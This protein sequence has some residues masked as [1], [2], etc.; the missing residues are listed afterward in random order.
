MKAILQGR[1]KYHMPKQVYLEIKER[2]KK[3]LDQGRSKFELSTIN[4]NVEGQLIS[5]RENRTVQRK[6]KHVQKRQGILNLQD[7]LIYSKFYSDYV[8][9]QKQKA[10][11]N[12]NQNNFQK[13]TKEIHSDEE[14]DEFNEQEQ[15][16][17]SYNI[18][19]LMRNRTQDT[20]VLTSIAQKETEEMHYLTQMLRKNKKNGNNHNVQETIQNRNQLKQKINQIVDDTKEYFK[21]PPPLIIPPKLKDLTTEQVDQDF[22]RLIGNQQNIFKQPTKQIIQKNPFMKSSK[23][24]EVY[25]FVLGRTFRLLEFNIEYREKV[26]YG[27]SLCC[28]KMKQYEEGDAYINSLLNEFDNKNLKY[29]YLKAII[30]KQLRKFEIAEKYYAELF[31]RVSPFDHLILR[32]FMFAFLLKYKSKIKKYQNQQLIFPPRIHQQFV[33]VCHQILEKTIYVP[34]LSKFWSQQKKYWIQDKFEEIVDTIHKLPF[35]KRLAKSVVRKFL[36]ELKFKSCNKNQIMHSQLGTSLI[37]ISGLVLIYDHTQQF[38]KPQIVAQYSKGKNTIYFQFYYD[39]FIN[40]GDIICGN[41]YENYISLQANVW[42]IAQSDKVEYLEIEYKRFKELWK[43]QETVDGET[44]LQTLKHLKLFQGVSEL[45]LY[46]LAYELIEIKE[47]KKGD[48]IYNDCSYIESKQSDYI[49]MVKT[50]GGKT[51]L[52]YIANFFKVQ[53]GLVQKQPQNCRFHKLIIKHRQAIRQM[54]FNQKKTGGFYILLSGN[55]E[56]E[57]DKGL[58]GIHLQTKDYFGENLMIDVKGVANFGRIQASSQDVKCLMIPKYLFAKINQIDVQNSENYPEFNNQNEQSNINQSQQKPRFFPRKTKS[59]NLSNNQEDAH[60]SQQI[61]NVI[62]EEKKENN[63]L[64][65]IHQQS[66]QDQN[67][68]QKQQKIPQKCQNK[69]IKQSQNLSTNIKPNNNSQRNFNQPSQIYDNSNNI[70]INNNT[71][72]NV[73]NNSNN[74]QN[75][76]NINNINTNN[77]QELSDF[78]Q[79][80]QLDPIQQQQQN[81]RN[82][83][84]VRRNFAFQV[85]DAV[86]ESIIINA[87]IL[88]VSLLK[89]VVSINVIYGED[90]N[91]LCS[92]D[93]QNWLFLMLFYDIYNS[94]TILVLM[95]NIY[96]AH[97][98]VFFQRNSLQILVHRTQQQL[99]QEQQQQQNQ[100]QQQQNQEHNNNHFE[101]NYQQQINVI[102]ECK[103]EQLSNSSYDMES[104]LKNSLI[105]NDFQPTN[106]TN[107]NIEKPEKYNNYNRQLQKFQYQSPSYFNKQDNEASSLVQEHEEKKDEEE[108]K[109]NK[110]TQN[111][112]QN[113]IFQQSPTRRKTRKF[114]QSQQ[115]ATANSNNNLRIRKQS[116]MSYSQQD[117]ISSKVS[118]IHSEVSN[119]YIN[120]ELINSIQQDDFDLENYSRSSINGYHVNRRAENKYKYLKPLNY[121]GKLFYLLIFLYGNY[122][123]YNIDLDCQNQAP[124][125]YYVAVFYLIL[126]YIYLG[127]PLFLLTSMCLCLPILLVLYFFIRRRQDVQWNPANKEF[128]KNLDRKKYSPQVIGKSINNE[129]C[130]CLAEYTQNDELIVLPCNKLHHFHSKCIVEWLENNGVCPICK[131]DLSQYYQELQEL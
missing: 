98:L 115:S 51:L 25:K 44:I 81:L 127:I 9:N 97:P 128:I 19:N 27:A 75:N 15:A 118:Q 65:L 64:S 17:Y 92:S 69:Y 91:V 12:I 6:L 22:E 57:N 110:V 121:V 43:S 13:N 36:P 52:Q 45:T 130:I 101:N 32:D 129:C 88:F 114:T 31:N 120:Q 111:Q 113:Q 16:L 109:V 82:A 70:N 5:L 8:Q 20:E 117:E 74:I 34:I 60:K 61:I 47:F 66:S 46:K 62:R 116:N 131:A 30:S 23:E 26:L 126:G 108:Q 123:L 77:N 94:F 38:D 37:I 3:V 63:K 42:M 106:M 53:D 14:D 78:T 29:I 96:I 103:F 11:L 99:Q 41:E 107:N 4:M 84:Q 39:I 90:N 76:N 72:N 7:D 21:N 104:S 112:H 125:Q 59:D 100:Q 93:I 35:F 55:V 56:I 85:Q 87:G 49:K 119:S 95:Y 124:H 24:R 105:K 1:K 102:E 50:K 28:Y 83:Y 54:Q 10:A 80:V 86:N 68:Q 33:D 71:N 89:I 58:R 40:I 122:V 2:N 18:E 73:N 79:S 67:N 48:V